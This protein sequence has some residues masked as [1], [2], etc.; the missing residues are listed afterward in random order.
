MRGLMRAGAGLFAATLLLRIGFAGAGGTMQMERVGDSRLL[1]SYANRVVP[2]SDSAEVGGRLILLA[3]S[4]ID[5]V[6]GSFMEAMDEGYDLIAED[7]GLVPSPWAATYLGMQSSKSFDMQSFRGHG[8]GRAAVIFLH[9]F[10]GNFTMPCWE[11]AQG[12]KAAGYDTFCPSTEWR[13]RWWRP[14]SVKTLRRTIEHVR[15][16][17]YETIVLAGLSN[18]GIGLSKIAPQ[19]RSE[20]SGFIF[21][22]GVASTARPTGTPTLVIHGD[23]DEMT[24]TSIARNY[25]QGLERGDYLEL[26]GG[27][28]ILIE[29]R[30]EVREKLA[31]WLG[32]IAE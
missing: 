7:Q 23:R 4:A 22:S 1:A 17:G 15:S 6:D 11:V 24:E 26:G 29:D 20:A 30:R 13:G 5:D 32:A 28:F 12:V 25:A 16:R 19:F 21:L 14:D 10:G 2:E 27:H 3:S 8:D 31:T 9:G 18:G